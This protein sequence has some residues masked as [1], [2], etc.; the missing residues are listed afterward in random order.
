VPEETNRKIVDHISDFNLVYTEHARRH[1][2]SEGIQHRRIYLTGSPMREVLD[3]Y[4]SQIAGSNV[5]NLLKLK[6]GGYFIVSLHRE[7]NVD[8]SIRLQ[9]LQNALNMLAHKYNFPVI[10]STHPRTRKRLEALG[11]AVLHPHV[12][13]M[14]PFG[15]HDYNK[16][17]MNAFCAISDSGTIAEES[18]ILDFP[19][20]TPRDAIERPEALDVGCI[21]MTGLDANT[22]EN[23][24]TLVTSLHAERRAMKE[25]QRQPLDYQITNTAERVVSLITGTAKLSNIWDGVRNNDLG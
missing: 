10:V 8:N 14:K 23:A 20:I 15:F 6:A 16:L 2:L 18:S 1:L 5:L 21:T 13:Y 25:T 11:A 12:Q 24:V 9:A 17:Q 22:I 19:A 3:F 4:K 7:E